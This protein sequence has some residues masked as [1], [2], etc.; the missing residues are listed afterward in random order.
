MQ[1]Y[2]SFQQLSPEALKVLLCP[3]TKAKRVKFTPEEDQFIIN[4]VGDMRFPNWNQIAADLGKGKSSKQIR[5]RYQHYLAPGLSNDPW[6]LEE[7][8]L[9]LEL[10]EQYGSNWSLISSK[11]DGRRS[12]NSVKNRYYNHLRRNNKSSPLERSMESSPASKSPTTPIEIPKTFVAPQN[13]NEPL[14]FKED[15]FIFRFDIIDTD[16]EDDTFEF[17]TL[18]QL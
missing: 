14:D 1:Q 17:G 3:K 15:D 5:E 6:T 9:I 13:V 16:F 7:D 8:Q 10:F 4:S 12:N 18:L 11:F 2:L